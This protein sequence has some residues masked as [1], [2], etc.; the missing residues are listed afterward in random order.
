MIT[1]TFLTISNIPT[2]YFFIFL[3]SVIKKKKTLYNTFILKLQIIYDVKCTR[4][5]NYFIETNLK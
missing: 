1:I 5:N 2:I 3:I 4:L